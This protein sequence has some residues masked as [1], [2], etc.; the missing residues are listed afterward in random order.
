[1]IKIII[2]LALIILII[3]TLRIISNIQYI[4]NDRF[5][6]GEFRFFHDYLKKELKMTERFDGG[7]FFIFVRTINFKEE[8]LF[9][10]IG[11]LD[12]FN[13]EGE[14]LC[15]FY[16]NTEHVRRCKK[17]KV[18][19]LNNNEICRKTIYDS[20]IKICKEEFVNQLFF[21]MEK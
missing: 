19:G 17:I 9:F 13:N 16:L 18:R 10:E 8:K 11:I 20:L 7:D 3:V 2:I 4:R 6:K 21:N 12:I 14:F 5:L 15:N 1:M